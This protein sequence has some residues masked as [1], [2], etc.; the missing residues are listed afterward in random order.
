MPRKTLY[1]IALVAVQVWHCR[2]PT[3]KAKRVSAGGRS[4]RH[5]RSVGGTPV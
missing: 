2:N 3:P 1:L 5:G 4:P